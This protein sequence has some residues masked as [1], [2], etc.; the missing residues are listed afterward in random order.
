MSALDNMFDDSDPEDLDEDVEEKDQ[1]PAR[2]SSA[3]NNSSNAHS[4]L[5]SG[6][7]NDDEG[8]ED[9][10]DDEDDEDEDEE[11]DEDEEQGSNRRRKRR[12]G[13]RRN[14]FLDVEAEVDEDEEEL[15]ED[16]DELGR[17]DGFIAD[18]NETEFDRTDDRLHRE[19][20]RQRAAI[21]EEDAERLASEYREKYGRSAASKYRG[22]MNVIP[23]RLLVPSVNSPN[24]WGV[25]CKQGKEREIIRTLYHK[26]ANMRYTRNPVRILSAF[27]R[28]SFSGYIY[29]EAKTLPDVEHALKGV[30]NVYF[31]QMILIPIEEY[32][33]LLRVNKSS[34]VELIP[35]TYVR[36]KRGRYAG[37]L[38]VV[39]DLSEN[40]LEARLKVVP[41]LDYGRSLE[42]LGQAG[43]DTT[44][45]KRSNKLSSRP[46]A[47]LFSPMEARRSDPKNWQQRQD[48]EN[49]YIFQGEEYLNG[50][51]L[52]D[53]K[54]THLITENVEPTLEE[55]TK[56]SMS[57]EDEGI[58]LQSLAQSLKQ[59]SSVV[60]FQPGDHV[61][62]HEGEQTGLAGRVVSIDRD[63]VTIRAETEGLKG[64]VVEL[65]AR[66]LRK[67]FNAGDH[68][69][70]IGGKYKDETG[71]VVRVKD[72]IVTII[73]DLSM[74]EITVF[75][76]DLKEAS[77][78]GGRNSLGKYQIHDL[79]QLSANNVACIIKVERD[80]FRVLDINGIAQTILPSA[81]SM[82]VDN[83]FSFATD[84]N[85][86]EI[87]VGDTVKE[88]DGE[89][90]Q[91]I[92][93]HIY[94]TFAFIH[95][96]SQND[97]AGVSLVRTRNVQAIAAKGGRVVNTS[98]GP[99]FSKMNPRLQI[100]S[101]GSMPPPVRQS[102]GRDRT[103]GQS[104]TIR[105][106]PYKGL[107]GII[108]D[109]TDTIARVEL[110]SKS[111]IIS[112]EKTKLGY[113]D[114][115]GV[116]MNYEDF[117]T[118]RKY[119]NNSVEPIPQFQGDTRDWRQQGGFG[120][121]TP[122]RTP[123]WATSES[124]G[125]GRTPAWA[126]GAKTPSWGGAGGKTPAWGGGGDGG[127]TPAWGTSSA[128]SRTPAWNAGGRTPAYGS[129]G[130][131]RTPAWNPGSRTPATS[132][133][134]ASSGRTPRID[135]GSRTPAW[136]MQTG[137]DYSTNART[138]WDES[139]S[140]GRTP[141]A[142]AASNSVSYHDPPTVAYTPG[143]P[144]SAPTPGII[145]VSAPTPG[146]WDD[147]AA[148]PAVYDARTPGISAA[149]PAAWGDEAETPRYAPASP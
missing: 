108:K 134:D 116:V 65:P 106:G 141:G 4:D 1:A 147:V 37:D 115:S 60:S 32:T 21:A 26:Q 125:G 101:A 99:D 85:G 64:E 24:I 78:I 145:G 7:N 10:G 149:T 92:I 142:S 8:D 104:V 105:Q 67:K 41:R 139:S 130:G 127:R 73:G 111:K 61:E 76:K 89:G 58:D 23:Q 146:A 51:L 50:Y 138:P 30:V 68:V 69:R 9:D 56:F 66:S 17:E 20:D 94:R 121:Q 49:H 15:E 114:R 18:A 75:S 117:L 39:E 52:K 36:I 87:R 62:V 81:I 55:V 140:Y 16:E 14:Q 45:R 86:S 135:S 91:G 119:L 102:G 6:E 70:V 5:R 13:E 118:P 126:S 133:W 107:I 33:D 59:T 113:K 72:E 124:S 132:A 100:G 128:S 27:Q 131:G 29:I 110:H 123:A 11:D 109:A 34:E 31:R 28:E 129:S 80:A 19:V 53:F 38:A 93:L 77:D 22:E 79:V 90:R 112:I 137:N 42:I 3:N 148:T 46:A 97:N 35:G 96:R 48:R 122:A 25:R 88:T 83:K 74:V 103:I 44:K 144:M 71:M 136:S 98:D 12:R 2:S 120:G 143:G 82:K 54:L 95:D 43:L 40:G 84:R 57:Q 63:I 47:R